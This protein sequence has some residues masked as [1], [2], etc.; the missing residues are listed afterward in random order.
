MSLQELG[1]FTDTLG[2]SEEMPVLFLGHGSPMIAIEENQFVKGFRDIVQKIPTPKAILC[3]SAHWETRGTFVTAMTTP[4]TIHD[5]GGFPQ[6]LFDVQ[7]PA[8]GNP[9]LAQEIKNLVQSTEVGLD[10]EWGLDHGAWTVIKHMYP[11]ANIPI[12]EFSLDYRKTPE[13]HYQLAEELKTLRKKGVLIIGSGNIVHNLRA[14]AWNRINDTFGF[15]W[16]LEANNVVKTAIMERNHQLLM[17]P[18]E[19]GQAFQLAIP[20]PEH[21]LPLLYALAL[22]GNK[23]EIAFFNDEPVAGSL[24]MTS[25]YIGKNI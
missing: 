1:K 10:V 8:A 19:Q 25:V 12:V 6:A 14:V 13:Q 21:Y 7:Y 5:F 3:V 2:E 17:N 4:P 23:D 15:D 22:Q 16:A 11:D 9:A 18:F 20:T 24:S